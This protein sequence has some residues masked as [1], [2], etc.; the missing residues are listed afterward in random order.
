MTGYHG[1]KKRIGKEIAD[2]IYNMVH[3]IEKDSGIKFKGYCE[4][5]CGML[6]VY[7]HIP[8]LF[9]DHK[10]KMKF[11][12]GDINESVIKMWKKAQG[13]WKPPIKCTKKYYME[14]RNKPTSSAEK[15]FIGSACAY[16]G[17]YFS[18]TFDNRRNVEH[19]SDNVRR[20]SQTLKNVDFNHE[21]YSQFSHLKDYI[22]YCD[23]PYFSKSQFYDEKKNKLSFD[24]G[25]FYDWVEKLSENNLIF[26]S[27]RAKL[28]Y[29][30]IK[31][32]R[33][34]EKLFVV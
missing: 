29:T 24:Y 9:E 33:D 5:F 27:E 30:K 7:Q 32:M 17:I 26:I 15:G 2:S 10:P 1:G 28:P 14:L 3:C 19:A 25:A 12:A 21:M 4:P 31:T 22:I 20:V 23:P 18:S 11:K 16:R 13:G 6:G 8:E 34:G